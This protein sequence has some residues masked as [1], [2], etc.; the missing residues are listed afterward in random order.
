MTDREKDRRHGIAC[1]GNFIVDI[2]HVARQFPAKGDLVRLSG[3]TMG[4]GGG[5]ANVLAD[6]ASFGAGFPLHAIGCIGADSHGQF[7]R[8]RF[9]RIGV[10]VDGLVTLPDA[11]TAY[12]QVMSVPG[13]SRTF[14]Y[15]GGANDRFDAR[16]V[17]LDALSRAS[18]KIFYLGYLMLLGALDQPG[19]DGRTGASVLLQEARANGLLTCVD[20]VSDASPAFRDIVRPSLPHCDFL[21]INEIEAERASARQVR[22]AAGALVP[23][24]MDQAAENLLAEGVRE[25]VIIHAP[26]GA[27]WAAR[28]SSPLFMPSVQVPPSAIVSPVGAGDAFCAGILYGLH[29]GWPREQTLAVAHRAA[30]ACLGGATATDGIPPIRDLLG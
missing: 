28:G 7:I 16:H 5:A 26:E 8:E 11:L 27:L 1:A 2:V 4:V 3:N 19:P 17:P 21:I 12:C 9:D 20:L 22:D 23:G 10:S 18:C 6:L 13:D 14:F 30:A 24:G 29:E 25:A 15:H